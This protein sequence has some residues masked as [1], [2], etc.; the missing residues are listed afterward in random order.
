MYVFLCTAIYVGFIR[1]V[2][3]FYGNEAVMIFHIYLL[4]RC[5]R[6]RKLD[7]IIPLCEF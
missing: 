7:L 6:A 4:K 3:F 1:I 5:S 2:C